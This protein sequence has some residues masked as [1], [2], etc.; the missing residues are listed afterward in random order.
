MPEDLDLHQLTDEN[1]KSH[2]I[3]NIL[4]DFNVCSCYIPAI[5]AMELSV[6]NN[7]NICR[8]P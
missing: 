2:I 3:Q 4:T 5:T 8:N 7:G 1:L 6:I